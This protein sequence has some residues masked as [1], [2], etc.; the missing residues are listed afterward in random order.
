VLAIVRVVDAGNCKPELE[1]D[2][3]HIHLSCVYQARTP[4]LQARC[5]RMDSETG[6]PTAPGHTVLPGAAARAT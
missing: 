1:H 5:K 2:E 3:L 4:E 6:A